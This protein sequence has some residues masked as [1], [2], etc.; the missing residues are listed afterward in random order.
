MI[1][2]VKAWFFLTKY[3]I[4]FLN[5]IGLL[6]PIHQG[7]KPYGVGGILVRYNQRGGSSPS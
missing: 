2:F 6:N 3:G 5:Q 1:N 7:V 4:L